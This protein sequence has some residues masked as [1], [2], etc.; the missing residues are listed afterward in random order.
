MKLKKEHK[1]FSGFPRHKNNMKHFTKTPNIFFDVLIKQLTPSEIKVL[2]K[3][4]RE[5]YGWRDQETGRLKHNAIIATSVF[6]EDM[7]MSNRAVIDAIR[8]LKKKNIIEVQGRHSKGKIYSVIYTDK[9]KEPE[10]IS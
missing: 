2:S 6:E 5:T 4:I 3:I 9:H 1:K 8:S 10:N 7:N